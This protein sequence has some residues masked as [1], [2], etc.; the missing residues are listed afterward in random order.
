MTGKY[1]YTWSYIYEGQPAE[2][3]LT[4][5]LTSHLHG[6]VLEVG[7]GHGDYTKQWAELVEEMVGYDMTEGFLATAE[8]NRTNSN[9]RYVLGDTHDGLPFPDNT[10]DVAYT[11]KGP[12]SWYAEGN[13]VVRPGG[14]L[15][16]FHPGDSNEEGGELGRIFPG[17]FALPSAGTPIPD[18]IQ[19]RL[20]TS[21]LTVIELSVLKETIWIPSPDVVL[22]MICFGQSDGFRQYAREA[23]Y[24]QIVSQFENHA[25]AQGIK[26][27][28]FYYFIEAKAS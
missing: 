13:R 22:E 23:G 27:T 4:E 25:S 20:E 17:L 14:T 7:C 9:V 3:R 8:R 19:E 16:L 28:A 18:K 10:F 21:G 1:E 24:Q 5:K 11:K 15:L 26:T 2:N 6:K 12:T